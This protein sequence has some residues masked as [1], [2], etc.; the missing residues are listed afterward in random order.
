MWLSEFALLL[1][2]WRVGCRQWCL[3]HA[4]I[5]YMLLVQLFRREIHKIEIQF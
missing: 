5:L 2:F 3:D 1:A 4:G